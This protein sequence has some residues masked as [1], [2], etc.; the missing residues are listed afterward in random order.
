[1]TIDEVT[2]T[3]DVPFAG[4]TLATDGAASTGFTVENEKE[5]SDAIWSGGSFASVSVT[6]VAVTLTAQVVPAGSGE[7]G[8]SVNAA[9]GDALCV[10]GCGE[11]VGHWRLNAVADA[12]TLSLKL[13]T[14]VELNATLVA[15]LSGVVL[16][17]K[18]AGSPPPHGAALV[19]D[20]RGDTADTEKSTLLRSVSVQPPTALNADKVAEIVPV[21]AVPSKQFVPA[22]YP[23]KSTIDRTG[24]AGRP[25]CDQRLVIDQR[26]LTGPCR[27]RNGGAC[28]QVW[29]RKHRSDSGV[30][31][32]G[33]QEITA[34]RNHARQVRLRPR[35]SG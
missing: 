1:M 23:T 6:S 25:V 22:P 27:H 28:G 31:A 14:M 32:L 18:G 8:V 2:G 33:D 4:V 11:P 29:S 15:R 3:L 17:T 12:V 5:K 19:P 35:A 21:G 26:H 9:A 34:R 20:Q 7:I 24:R 13:M 30:R 10:N 16:L